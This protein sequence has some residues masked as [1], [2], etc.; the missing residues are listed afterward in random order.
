M[1]LAIVSLKLAVICLANQCYPVL[2]GEHTPTGSFPVTHMATTE[3]GY[4]G[5]VL[6][7]AE[8]DRLAYS[9][10]RVWLGNP[11]Q[12]REARL[13]SDRP[14]DRVDVTHGCINVDPTTFQALLDADVDQLEVE[15]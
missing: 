1:S 8:D 12:H 5:D 2:V 6:Q 13:R 15:P 7:F 3:P 14:E 4:G 10:H 11:K 9:I